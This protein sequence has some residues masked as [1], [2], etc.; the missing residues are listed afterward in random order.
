MVI[1]Y[2]QL[3]SIISPIFSFETIWNVEK[4]YN[5][6]MRTYTHTHVCVWSTFTSVSVYVESLCCTNTH[7]AN[8]IPLTFSHLSL[9]G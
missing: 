7:H 3:N 6:Q 8:P 4:C 5:M 9:H 2:P 1:L